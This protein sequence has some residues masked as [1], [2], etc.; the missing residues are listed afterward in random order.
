MATQVTS[1]DI[2]NNN[3]VSVTKGKTEM[4]VLANVNDFQIVEDATQ[5]DLLQVLLSE[6]R[7]IDVNCTVGCETKKRLDLQPLQ[8]YAYQVRMF[9]VPNGTLGISVAPA[10]QEA[11]LGLK[12]ID[13]D[14]FVHFAPGDIIASVNGVLLHKLTPEFAVNIF[15]QSRDRHLTVIRGFEFNNNDETA[16]RPPAGERTDRG[17]HNTEQP[18]SSCG[19]EDPVFLPRRSGSY[20]SF[21]QKMRTKLRDP[22]GE[23]F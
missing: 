16:T 3:I 1:I 18:S 7:S 20:H 10:P 2:Y 6:I 9:T 15:S 8:K 13:V 5:N 23:I 12:I 4:G 17:D 14:D 19:A 11:E 22:I 21:I